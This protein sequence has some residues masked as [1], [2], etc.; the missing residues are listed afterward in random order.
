[1]HMAEILGCF[2]Q[3]CF[4][5]SRVLLHLQPYRGVLQRPIPREEGAQEERLDTEAFFR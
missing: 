3:F 1:M 4:S 2:D 5:P